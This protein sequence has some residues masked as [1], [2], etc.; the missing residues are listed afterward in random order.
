MLAFSLSASPVWAKQI[1]KDAP[2]QSLY[3]QLMSE[4]TQRPDEF[5][6]Y[7]NLFFGDDYHPERGKMRLTTIFAKADAHTICYQSD[8]VDVG[9]V[10]YMCEVP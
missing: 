3:E 5:T 10:D 2:A 8:Y 1:I 7:S 9:M 6:M 4:Q